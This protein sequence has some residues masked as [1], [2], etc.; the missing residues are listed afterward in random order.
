M[1]KFVILLFVAASVF[2]VQQV[3]AWAGLGHMAIAQI[4][5][6]HLT[7]EAKAVTQKYLNASLP[8][9]AVWMDRTA[10]WNKK[11]KTYIPGW[12][13]T[14]TWHT[15]VVDKKYRVS[16]V[17]TPKGSGNLVPSL[18]MCIDNLKN[19]R[20]LTDSAVV[21]NLK[22]VVHM[23]G[24][25]HCPTHIYYLEFPDCFRGE[26]DANGKRR[27]ARDRIPVYF[28]GKKMTYHAFW[29]GVGLSQLYP[30]H[31]KDYKFFANAVD[32]ASPKQKAKFCKG[33]VDGWV[34]DSAKSCRPVYDK[35]KASDELDR[36]FILSYKKMTEK[37]VLKGGCRLAYVLNEC[38]K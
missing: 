35:V 5:E 19:Y 8:S 3:S 10:S 36:D 38:F 31:G 23:L 21:V 27:P 1:K 12:N 34:H 22:C 30:G 6:N 24:D 14:S 20:N 28:N 29:D 9:V 25:M 11:R 15:L 7:P 4:A 16:K 2:S 32:T 26:K 13:Q 37:Q 17:Q 18:K 33:G